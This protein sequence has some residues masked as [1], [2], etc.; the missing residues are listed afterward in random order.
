M[1]EGEGKRE[2]WFSLIVCKGR[3]RERSGLQL[4]NG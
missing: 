4:E 2:R 1:E 3:E